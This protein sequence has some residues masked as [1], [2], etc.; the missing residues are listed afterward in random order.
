VTVVPEIAYLVACVGEKTV[1]WLDSG[2]ESD[3]I[4]AKIANLVTAAC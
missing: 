2:A 1:T 4:D 3:E